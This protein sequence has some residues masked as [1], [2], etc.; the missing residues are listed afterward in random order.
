VGILNRVISDDSRINISNS[1]I[2]L[3]KRLDNLE[4][5]KDDSPVLSKSAISGLL[6]RKSPFYKKRL[7][8]HRLLKSFHTGNISNFTDRDLREQDLLE[9]IIKITL[10][11]AGIRFG[12]IT[13]Q[14]NREY[15]NVLNSYSWAPFNKRININYTGKTKVFISKIIPAPYIG[16]EFSH[17][18]SEYNGN[19]IPCSSISE[20]NHAVNLSASSLF[21]EKGELLFKGLRHGVNS[22]YGINNPAERCAAN[23]ARVKEILKAAIVSDP[24]KLNEALEKGEISIEITSLSLLTPDIFRGN[25][26]TSTDKIRRVKN[27]NEKL[28][29]T[30]QINA[31]RE[32]DLP[33]FPGLDF[34]GITIRAQDGRDREIRVKPQIIS[35][36]FGVNHGAVNWYSIITGGWA[37]SDKINREGMKRLFGKAGEYVR[38]LENQINTF[39]RDSDQRKILEDKLKIIR[40][41]NI[42]IKNIWQSENYKV[43]GNDPYKM[44]SRLGLL[45]YMLGQ[46]VC[47]NC[48]SGKDR[49]G[50]LDLEIK[51]LI[52]KIYLTG[53]V[54]DYREKLTEE[55]K[56][57]YRE[58]AFN[59]GNFELQK[60]NVGAFGFKL[61]GVKSITERLGGADAKIIYR[62]LSDYFDS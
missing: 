5:E 36:N 38:K 44:V 1:I 37:V 14:L 30:E 61:E 19:G 25:F 4:V 55:D 26:F 16:G 47:W 31:L 35:F 12:N 60:Y 11:R 7:A 45:S 28:M 29:L 48:K 33:S 39:T 6:G 18:F 62:G 40:E 23:K 59:S 34:T 2:I 24:E 46:T 54:P 15:L 53:K 57:I 21:T 41:L 8:T 32:Y 10:K 3:E 13:E 17:S 9:I 52:I 42:Q 51:F 43:S 27:N 49:T 58:V 50:Q 20:K 22:A 56:L